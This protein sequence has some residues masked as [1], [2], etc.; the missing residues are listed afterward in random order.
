MLLPVLLLLLLL[1]LLLQ[2]IIA[3]GRGK[4][5]QHTY[6]LYVFVHKYYYLSLKYKYVLKT[7]KTFAK[8]NIDIILYILYNIP[9]NPTRNPNAYAYAYAYWIP[10][11]W[12]PGFPGFRLLN[13]DR[14]RCV[15]AHTTR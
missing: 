7:Y 8:Y 14:C 4:H 3:R 11:S 10:G 2:S 12:F 15:D 9:R 5:K 6:N 13:I 1:L